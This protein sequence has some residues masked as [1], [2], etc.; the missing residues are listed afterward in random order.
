MLRIVRT[1]LRRRHSVTLAAIKSDVDLQRLGNKCALPQLI[2]DVVRVEGTVV[3]ADTG[4][5]SPVNKMRAAEV[6]SNEGMQQRLARACIAHLDWIARLNY[7]SGAEIIVDH[8]LDRASAHIGWNVACLQFSE[9][10]MNE[11]TV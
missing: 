11:D 7:R 8:R 1:G 9:Y 10:L 3:V 4:M 6:L 2:E 5:V